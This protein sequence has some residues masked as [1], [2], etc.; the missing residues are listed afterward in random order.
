M[1]STKIRDDG[2]L[3]PVSGMA[4]LSGICVCGQAAPQPERQ[5]PWV[6]QGR[7]SGIT[8]VVVLG[9]TETRIQPDFLYP[10]ASEQQMGLKMQACATAALSGVSVSK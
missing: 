9:C 4:A 3:L 2:L 10:A 8:W 6:E 1:C 7:S 5:N